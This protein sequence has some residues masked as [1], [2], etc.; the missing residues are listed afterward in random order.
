MNES[1]FFL[2]TKRTMIDWNALN[3][4]LFY[5]GKLSKTTLLKIFNEAR[6]FI[7]A[8]PNL[9]YLEDPINIVGDI[10]GQYYDI[11]EIFRIGG[12]PG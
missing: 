7:S 11:K 2:K 5:E 1:N 12:V 6:K 9:L 4:H 8:E 3:H 10:H